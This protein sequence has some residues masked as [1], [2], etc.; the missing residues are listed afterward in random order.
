MDGPR[1]HV[2][3]ATAIETN[4]KPVRGHSAFGVAAEGLT[5]NA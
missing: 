1:S 5:R 3:A 4:G 2:N